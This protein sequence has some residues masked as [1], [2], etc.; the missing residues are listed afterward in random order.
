MSWCLLNNYVKKKKKILECILIWHTFIYGVC[1]YPTIEFS[2]G[3]MLLWYPCEDSFWWLHIK[4]KGTSWTKAK[5]TAPGHR[6]IPAPPAPFHRV[7]PHGLRKER[8][9]GE[10]LDFNSIFDILCL[11]SLT[12][13]NCSDEAETSDIIRGDSTIQRQWQQFSSPFFFPSSTLFLSLSLSL[14]IP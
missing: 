5:T 6:F 3:F 1:I 7:A 12:H 13:S 14:I 9:S 2:N 8:G 11:G 4:Y 10:G